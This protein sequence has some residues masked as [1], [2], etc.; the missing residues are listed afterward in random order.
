MIER[1][2]FLIIE[3]DFNAE[4]LKIPFM[5]QQVKELVILFLAYKIA[6]LIRDVLQSL[7]I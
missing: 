5:Y 3:H 4:Q 1:E 6:F 2:D 7:R